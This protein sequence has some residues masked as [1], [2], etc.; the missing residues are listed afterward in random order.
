LLDA[1]QKGTSPISTTEETDRDYYYDNF[2]VAWGL[3]IGYL[4]RV[5]LGINA[6]YNLGIRNIVNENATT[7]DVGELRNMGLQIG[8]VYQFGAHK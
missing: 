8:L 4:S 5:G 3:G 7:G 2:D 1:K 6:R